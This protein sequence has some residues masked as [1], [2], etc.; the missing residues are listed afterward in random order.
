MPLEKLSF[1]PGVNTQVSATANEGGWS[2]SS[3]VHFRDGVPEK[4][5]GWVSLCA[6]AV[7]G[8]ARAVWTWSQLN[9]QPVAA[10]GTNSNLHLLSQG[11][12]YNITPSRAITTGT[13]NLTTTSGSTS[14][15]VSDPNNGAVVGDVVGIA[16]SAMVGG[17]SIN[18]NY[19]IASVIDEADFTI[20]TPT[21]A[22]SSGAGGGTVTMVYFLG[23]GPQDATLEFG[24]GAGPLGSGP[25]GEPFTHSSGFE[26]RPAN[27]SLDNFGEI[28]LALPRGGT[29]YA[30]Q[31][32]NGSGTGAQAVTNPTAGA[33]PPLICEAMFVAMPEQHVVLL[34][35]SN[36]GS[37]FG[38]DPMQVTF[39]DETDYTTYGSTQTN[40]AGAQTLQG[41]TRLIC[42]LNT[43]GAKLIWSDEALFLMQFIGG[44][45]VY[46]FTIAGQQCGI[47]GPHAMCTY[48]GVVYWMGL[49]AFFLFQ[50]G[51][52]IEIPCTIWH[53]VFGNL[54]TEQADKVSCGLNTA[55]NSIAWFYPSA[56]SEENDSFAEWNF[57]EQVWSFGP[58]GAL[59]R[60]AW[61]DSAVFQFPIGVGTDGILYQHE[62]GTDANGA[63][64]VA[65]ITS[66]FSDIADG[67]DF[68]FID[69]F[70]PDFAYQSGNV[71]I[72]AQSVNYPNG[73]VR[74]YGPFTAAPGTQFISCRIRGRQVS[75]T[76]AT[77]DL[78]ADF[79]LGA[80]RINGQPDGRN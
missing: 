80:V 75:F 69:K 38:F 63:P 76:F 73:P 47:I 17:L 22:T 50:G 70:M 44:D 79:R 61:V 51:A 66:G 65:S 77:Q 7:I 8:A 33:G 34:G 2:A 67:E 12:L 54:N 49:H 3:M 29:L 60:A 1:R 16:S 6:T 23:V 58:S 25:V 35:T 37:G 28:L 18:G 72:T 21:A 10:V 32:A 30:W 40:S 20:T 68:T 24:V 36:P 43:T 31:P 15:L 14:V 39:S 71:Y 53:S 62:Q 11:T 56:A 4:W 78:G 19:T 46:G 48:G 9:G 42:G 27:W 59:E 55:R 5:K 26:V 74:T 13:N 57:V 41:G 64:L 45:D 52:P